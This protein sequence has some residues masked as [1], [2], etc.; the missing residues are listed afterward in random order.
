[1]GSDAHSIT[2]IFISEERRYFWFSSDI[3]LNALPKSLL[4]QSLL[5]YFGDI[6]RDWER[7]QRTTTLH[8]WERLQ[9][10]IPPHWRLLDQ[11][12]KYILQR[13]PLWN[14]WEYVKLITIICGNMCKGK[15]LVKSIWKRIYIKMKSYISYGVCQVCSYLW[16][17]QHWKH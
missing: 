1:M 2:L 14:H 5:D 3:L 6:S 17:P 16:K 4:D 12:L 7:L 10:T 8:Y 11:Q 15:Q 9:I 13:T